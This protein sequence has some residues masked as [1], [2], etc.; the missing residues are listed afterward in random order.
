MGP[1]DAVSRARLVVLNG[2]S[3]IGKST[4]AQAYVESHPGTLNLD[5]DRVRT[6]IGGWRQDFVGTGEIVRSM[7]LAMA[8]SHLSNGRDV[9]V[10]QYLSE[11]QRTSY[12]GSSLRS[13]TPREATTDS[14]TC[15]AD[16]SVVLMSGP[17]QSSSA[18]SGATSTAH[19]PC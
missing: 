8:T 1:D 7:V 4:L 10:P 12:G 17:M 13:S 18:V 5:I 2:F 14:T 6:F 15:S 9:I 19:W 3:G 11:R 16:F